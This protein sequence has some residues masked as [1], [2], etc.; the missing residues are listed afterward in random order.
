MGIFH[1]FRPWM[2]EY[3]RWPID[4]STIYHDWPTL[5]NDSLVH[6]TQVTTWC[7]SWFISQVNTHFGCNLTGLDD[8]TKRKHYYRLFNWIADDYR[9]LLMWS[10]FPG[11]SYHLMKEAQGRPPKTRRGWGWRE[12]LVA[13]CWGNTWHWSLVP[14]HRRWCHSCSA[15]MTGALGVIS[16]R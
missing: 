12:W 1:Q 10:F 9:C 8:P 7:G 11:Y 2:Y 5:F 6:T 15:S 14:C 3:G 4:D 16:D 13:L